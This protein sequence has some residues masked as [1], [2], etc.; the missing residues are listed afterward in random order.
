MVHIYLRLTI[1]ILH[2]LHCV[3]RSMEKKKSTLVEAYVRK[4]IALSKIRLIEDFQSK[5][6]VEVHDLPDGSIDTNPFAWAEVDNIYM[7]VTKFVD[8]WDPKV[9]FFIIL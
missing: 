9:C 3:H 5:E 1:S 7:E 2:F 8:C 6:N 4:T